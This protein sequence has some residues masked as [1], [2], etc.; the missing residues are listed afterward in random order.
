[1]VQKT[2]SSLASYWWLLHIIPHLLVTFTSTCHILPNMCTPLPMLPPF[3]R[4]IVAMT[5]S[6]AHDDDDDDDDVICHL[7]RTSHAQV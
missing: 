1:M 7:P 6:I 2:C 5:Y 4:K 3:G